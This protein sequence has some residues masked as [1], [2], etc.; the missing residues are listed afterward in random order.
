MHRSV[1]YH[2]WSC[3]KDRCR[4]PRNPGYARYGGRGIGVCERWAASFEAFF[5]DMGPKPRGGSLERID[6]DAGYSPENCVW[7]DA[8]AQ[9]RNRSSNVFLTLDGVRMA[10]AAWAELLRV[11]PGLITERIGRGWSDEDALTQPPAK[12]GSW[13]RRLGSVTV[14][15]MV[16]LAF[17]P[18]AYAQDSE[19]G[20][21]DANLV[22]DQ[23]P[24]ASEMVRPQL[25]SRN[26]GAPAVIGGVSA[27]VGGLA[28]VGA[29]SVYIA[30]TSYRMTPRVSLSNDVIDSW[31]TMGAWSWWLGVGAS[32]LLVTSEYLLLPESLDVPTLAWIA[33]GAGVALAAVGIGYAVGGES[34]GPERVAPGANLRLACTAATADS[35]FGGLLILTA[36]PLINVP[37]VYLFRKLFAGAPESLS[38]GPGSVEWRGR[39]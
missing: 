3:M 18:A 25:V 35:V 11:N 4:N 6:N 39:F 1:E 27:A 29:W 19:S 15:T 33:G 24:V 21:V 20:L 5:A 36:L 34:C 32:S 37:A 12:N 22:G 17:S 8:K 23:S 9:S 14:V 38:I 13:R 10:A 28:L 16:L 26:R 7:T 31:S 30:R 2:T